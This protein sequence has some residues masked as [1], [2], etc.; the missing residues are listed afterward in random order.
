MK[1]DTLIR[2]GGLAFN[3][4]NNKEVQQLTGLVTKGVARRMNANQLPPGQMP[5]QFPMGQNMW[6]QGFTQQR[7]GQFPGH[8][9]GQNPNHWQGQFPGHWQGHQQGTPNHLATNGVKG[10]PPQIQ[11][12]WKHVTPENAQ[13]LMQWY[14]V[15]K[16][17]SGSGG[18]GGA[19]GNS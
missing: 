10:L 14:N 3:A 2:L 7:F 17:F 13:R 6:D 12:V 15:I 11:G 9:P 19:S 4:F 1:L 16:A 5:N 18:S 8:F